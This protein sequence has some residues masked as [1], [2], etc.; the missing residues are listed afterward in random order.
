ME[1]PTS[2]CRHVQPPA[3]SPTTSHPSFKYSVIESLRTGSRPFTPALTSSLYPNNV[4]PLT[5][6]DKFPC[7]HQKLT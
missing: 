1:G 7:I 6:H 5:S 4:S 2:S 3:S